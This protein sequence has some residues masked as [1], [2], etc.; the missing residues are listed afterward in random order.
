MQ[1]GG[2]PE[3]RLLLQPEEPLAQRQAGSRLAGDGDVLASPARDLHLHHAGPDQGGLQDRV[4]PAGWVLA[5]QPSH[6]PGIKS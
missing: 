2:E 6:E 3:Q 1:Q 5:L 4:K